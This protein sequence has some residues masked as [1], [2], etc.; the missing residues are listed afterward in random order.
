MPRKKRETTVA[1]TDEITIGLSC[2]TAKLPTTTSAAKSAPAM[3]ALKVAATPAAAPQA[4]ITRSWLAGT[5][6]SWPID[7]PSAD[8]IWTIGPSRPTEPPEPIEMAEASALTAT[9]R[10]RITPP[11]S[12]TAAI[13]S[14]TPWPLASRAKK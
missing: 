14:G 11:R 5:R 4:T 8:A 2:A 7:E 13:T 6:S 12:A 10:L 9:I 3:G 1:T